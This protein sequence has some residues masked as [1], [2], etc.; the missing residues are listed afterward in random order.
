MVFTSPS[1]F[2]GEI[3]DHLFERAEVEHDFDDRDQD[4]NED[5][6]EDDGFGEWPR[7]TRGSRKPRW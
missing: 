5:D 6:D 7:R 2:L 3:D 4:D 1:R